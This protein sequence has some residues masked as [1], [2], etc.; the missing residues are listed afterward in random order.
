M[1]LERNIIISFICFVGIHLNTD[2]QNFSI[3]SDSVSRVKHYMSGYGAKHPTDVSNDVGLFLYSADGNKALRLY[4]SFRMLLNIDNRLQYQPYQLDPPQ[5]PTG[6]DDYKYVHTNWSANM[7]LV[8]MDALIARKNGKAVMMRIEVDWKGKT[9]PFRVRHLFLRTP[10]WVIGQTWSS[11]TS[12]AFMART[13]EGHM[14]GAAS[15]IR[16]AQITYY[17]RKN[18][19]DYQIGLEYKVSGLI[20]PDSIA[21]NTVVT[22]PALAAR[23]IHTTKWGKWGVNGLLRTNTIKNTGESKESQYLLGYGITANALFKIFERT[24][25]KVSGYMGKG[26]Q[27]YVADYG[28]VPNNLIYNPQSLEFEEMEIYG[29][30]AV[31]QHGWNDEFSSSIAAGYNY[32]RNKIFQEDL[33]FNYSLKGLLNLFYTPIKKMKGLSVGIEGLYAERWNKDTSSNNAFRGSLLMSFDF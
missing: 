25:F 28:Y 11:Y 15:G 26:M 8:G 33:A 14:T 16:P 3:G 4:G 7:T 19:W 31:L 24:E 2:A 23:F 18:N 21:A 5:L 22:V 17:D 12:L 6:E 13:I 1:I 27:D 9:S 10:N 29:G 32:T 20:K 30:L